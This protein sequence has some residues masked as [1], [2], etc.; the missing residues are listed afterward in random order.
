MA[1][2]AEQLCENLPEEFTQYMQEVKAI[3][4]GGRPDYERLRRKFR[5][6]AAMEGVRYDNVFDWTKRHYLDTERA[7]R[8]ERKSKGK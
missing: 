5:S 2:S 8:K 1:T 4:N 3:P 7:R 6:L